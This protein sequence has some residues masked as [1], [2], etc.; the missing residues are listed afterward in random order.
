M[1]YYVT[2]AVDGRYV[3]EVEADNLRDA[4]YEAIDSYGNADFGELRDIINAEMIM[5]EDESG[6]YVWEK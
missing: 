4:K 1:K 2:F 3:A 5:V 6:A